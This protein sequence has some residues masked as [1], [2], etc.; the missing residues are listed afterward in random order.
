MATDIEGVARWLAGQR[1]IDG[2]G[3]SSGRV[4]SNT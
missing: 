2:D 1:L 4:M 3:G